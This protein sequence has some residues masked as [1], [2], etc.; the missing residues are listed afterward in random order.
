MCISSIGSKMLPLMEAAA[1]SSLNKFCL[2]IKISS[3]YTIYSLLSSPCLSL[4]PVGISLLS[5]WF[6]VPFLPLT[7]TSLYYCV[8]WSGICTT[9]LCELSVTSR[10]FGQ[11]WGGRNSFSFLRRAKACARKKNNVFTLC[12]FCTHAAARNTR[13]GSF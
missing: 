6:S 2:Y 7:L 4:Y 8:A 5:L 11:A 12:A 13:A 9:L 1:L 3:W 10:C